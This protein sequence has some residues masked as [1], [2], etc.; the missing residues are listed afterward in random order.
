MD[1]PSSFF[2][3]FNDCHCFSDLDLTDC[4]QFTF[5]ADVWNEGCG[6]FRTAVSCL[7]PR[8]VQLARA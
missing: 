3:R 5:F 2:V 1:Q 8:S 6:R 4:L 7:I